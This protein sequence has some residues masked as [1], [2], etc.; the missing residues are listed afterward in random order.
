MMKHALA[1]V[2]MLAALP[3]YA[4]FA[5]GNPEH[6]GSIWQDIFMKRMKMMREMM[7]KNKD[8]MISKD[9][10]MAYAEMAGGKQFMMLDMNN[11]GMVSE[12]EFMNPELSGSW[13]AVIFG[14]NRI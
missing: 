9:E 13:S 10:Y 8:G 11:D 12:A 7:D 5:P 4:Q 2:C 14:S 1:A 3:A 6:Y